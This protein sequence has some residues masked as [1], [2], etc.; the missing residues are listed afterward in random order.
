MHVQQVGHVSVWGC[1]QVCLCECVH[2]R[3]KCVLCYMEWSE[4]C[5]D[6]IA[7]GK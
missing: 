4:K 3:G 5:S 2:R 7:F 6:K 1:A